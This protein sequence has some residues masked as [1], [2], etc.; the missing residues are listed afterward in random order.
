MT[1]VRSRGRGWFARTLQWERC[2]DDEGTA[3][4]GMHNP[5]AVDFGESVR[6]AIGSFGGGPGG[7]WVPMSV[8][9]EG[10]L[11]GAIGAAAMTVGAK[12]EQRFTGRQN[13]HVPGL[14]LGRLIGV[15]DEIAEKSLAL[16]VAMHWGQAVV[17]GAWRSAMAS[18][19]LRGIGASTAFTG[20]RLLND[21]TLEN[22]TG[23]G[24]PPTTWPRR[25]LAIDVVHKAIY[26]FVTGLVADHLAARRGPGQGRRHASR[27]PGRHFNV[28]PAPRP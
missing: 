6:R 2:F 20:L 18:G 23:S 24:A 4:R 27:R 14:T 1:T 11:A 5:G 25:E 17:L 26:G 12:I 16:N 8:V 19:G 22:L 7:T 3:R 21:Q 13:S 9:G 15:P 10:L 28:G